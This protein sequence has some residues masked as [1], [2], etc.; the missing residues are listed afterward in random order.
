[1]TKVLR[2]RRAQR[3]RACAQ[4]GVARSEEGEAVGGAVALERVQ[5]RELA[6][7]YQR[8]LLGRDALFEDCAARPDRLAR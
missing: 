2:M 7:A 5:R 8:R 1:M 4:V 3:R 6:L